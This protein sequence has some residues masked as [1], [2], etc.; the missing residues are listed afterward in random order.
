MPMNNSLPWSHLSEHRALKKRESSKKF[1]LNSYDDIIFLPFHML[2]VHRQDLDGSFL[3]LVLG[4]LINKKCEKR[5]NKWEFYEAP[6]AFRKVNKL[7]FTPQSFRA[8]EKYF[9]GANMTV[10]V[11]SQK[12]KRESPVWEEFN[13]R[14]Q[15][16][17]EEREREREKFEE[18]RERFW[19][20]EMK[21]GRRELRKKG[22]RGLRVVE[23]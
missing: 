1:I 6:F 7:F 16:V 4:T 23:S 22:A 20:G 3:S 19:G 17:K 10:K 18:V 14:I 5:K 8:T 2:E 9:E 12:E 15:E 13:P 11:G 21:V